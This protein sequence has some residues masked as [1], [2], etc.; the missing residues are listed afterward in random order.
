M[1]RLVRWIVR[2]RLPD[3][4][5]RYVDV[6]VRGALRTFLRGTEHELDRT[7]PVRFG[8]RILLAEELCLRA[9]GGHRGTR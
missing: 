3:A 1:R 4:V 2:G 7:K 8:L 6:R 9:R 5:D